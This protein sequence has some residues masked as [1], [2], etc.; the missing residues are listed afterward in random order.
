[1]NTR[2]VTDE[3][4]GGM[5]ITLTGLRNNQ[6]LFVGQEGKWDAAYIPMFVRRYPFILQPG[7]KKGEYS[8]ML[9]SEALGFDAP[10]GQRLFNDDGSNTAMLADVLEVLNQFNGATEHTINFVKQ[11]RKL[12]LLTPR[13]INAKTRDGKDV[14]MNGFSVVDETKLNALG[15]AD[16]LGLARSGNLGGIYAHL[17]SLANIPKLVLR[18]DKAEADLPPKS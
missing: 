7:Q 9:D 2:F 12:D 4:D 3:K 16:L 13:G 8:V 17:F 18:I 5:P 6:N 1:M 11:L 14:Q 10:D 15:D